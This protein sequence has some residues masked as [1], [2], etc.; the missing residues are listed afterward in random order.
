MTNGTH[1]SSGTAFV[2]LGSNLGDRVG[3]LI[4]ALDALDAHPSIS[5]TAKSSIFET[6]PVGLIDQ[7]PYLNAVAALDTDLAVFELLNATQMIEQEFRRERGVRWGPRTLDLDI[8]LVGDLLID[9]PQLTVPHPRMAERR[10][11]LVPLAELAPD[12]VHPGLN[13]TIATLL[14]QLPAEAGDVVRFEADR[15][16]LRVA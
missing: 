5:V 15:Y 14:A 10:F 8:L 3:N 16:D 7:P 9:E 1:H 4:G 6:A 11:V 2:A 12:A 13:R